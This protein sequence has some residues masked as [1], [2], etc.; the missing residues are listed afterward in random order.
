MIVLFL[1]VKKILGVKTWQIEATFIFAC[2]LFIW[3]V[4][5]GSHI[6]G[7]GALAVFFTFM[8][9]SVANRL[10]EAEEKRAA[11]EEPL[12]VSCYK[13][14][15]RYY[16]AKEGLWLVYFILKVSVAGLAGVALFLVYPIW[17]NYYTK[18]RDKR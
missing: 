5:G 16:Y 14:L 3:L 11:K 13:L 6:E 12:L 18:R 17:R 8:H 10:E 7:I 15:N 2:L 1:K 4:S 9:A